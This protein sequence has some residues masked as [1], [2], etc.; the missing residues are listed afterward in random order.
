MVDILKS[1]GI[2]K[3]YLIHL[4]KFQISF[5][6]WKFHITVPGETCKERPENKKLMGFQEILIFYLIKSTKYKYAIS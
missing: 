2:E 5:K 1:V 6:N 4:L 3:A